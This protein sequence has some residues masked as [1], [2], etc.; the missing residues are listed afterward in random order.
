MQ[1]QQQSSK[2]K[3]AS[4]ASLQPED[5][6]EQLSNLAMP[7]RQATA[8]TSRQLPRQG[9]Q[10]TPEAAFSTSRSG[11][12][13]ETA[14]NGAAAAAAIAAAGKGLQL[15][16]QQ[17]AGLVASTT[18][19][20]SSDEIFGA[21]AAAAAGPGSGQGQGGS[22]SVGH[23]AT[24][25]AVPGEQGSG[26]SLLGQPNRQLPNRQESAQSRHQL[27]QPQ[28]ESQQAQH[29]LDTG[30]Q[31]AQQASSSSQQPQQDSF[32]AQQEELEFEQAST[33]QGTAP[34]GGSRG[35]GE[36][37]YAARDLT[38]LEQ[39]EADVVE[40]YAS[41]F[42]A[43]ALMQ[44]VL[45][46]AANSVVA[47]QHQQAL[48]QVRRYNALNKQRHTD[49]VKAERAAWEEHEANI[50]RYGG[51]AN[52][53]LPWTT[54]DVLVEI[55]RSLCW[56]ILTG[57]STAHTECVKPLGFCLTM[58]PCGDIKDLLNTLT[59]NCRSNVSKRST[60]L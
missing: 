11:V 2:A 58:I 15:S 25:V 6:A 3:L 30:S 53:G 45:P 26:D 7:V 20:Q 13:G 10:H 31:Q 46:A 14:H 28:F 57:A 37:V 27:L 55:D 32:R 43:E 47:E 34:R 42:V 19:Q 52:L 9:P 8:A 59:Q 29:D 23:G 39:Y 17:P 4:L 18:A 49:E 1:Q 41:S 60:G 16:P 21:D 40:A 22:S 44:H 38:V 50:K 56:F 48:D 54:L 5:S 51:H 24:S 33:S 12:K 35:P 36:S